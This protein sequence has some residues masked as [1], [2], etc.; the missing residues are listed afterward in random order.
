MSDP[1]DDSWGDLAAELGVETPKPV[2]P[3]RVE[4][5]SPLPTPVAAASL[6]DS[7]PEPDPT[8]LSSSLFAN[9]PAEPR[10][11]A[12]PKVVVEAAEEVAPEAIAH[13]LLEADEPG[14]DSEVIELGG[15]DEQKKRRRRRRRGKKKDGEPNGDAIET[16]DTDEAEVVTQPSEMLRDIIS[17]WDVPSWEEI[18]TGLHRPNRG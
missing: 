6:G 17:R 8:D 2:K 18:V 15:T 7:E 1:F 10:L 11:Q 14:A 16:E 13:M 5:P 12:A 9:L 4:P 3:V